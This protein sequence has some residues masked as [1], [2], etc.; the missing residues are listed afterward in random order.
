MSPLRKLVDRFTKPVD[1]VDR[2]RL[3]AFVE[4]L[5]VT[6]CDEL[7]T[8]RPVRFAGEIRSVRIVP[9]AGAPALEVTVNDGR[10]AVTAVFLG[11]RRIAGMTPGRRLIA[12]GVVVPQGGDRLVYNPWYRFLPR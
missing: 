11:R 12:E 4:G 1:E 6:P 10:A 9:R 8:R 3:V 7:P 5:D 2:E